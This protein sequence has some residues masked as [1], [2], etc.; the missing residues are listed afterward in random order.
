MPTCEGGRRGGG[1]LVCVRLYLVSCRGVCLVTCEER[2]ACG[3]V[4]F[5]PTLIIIH[6]RVKHKVKELEVG[7]C[8]IT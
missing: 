7:V 8:M 3:E 5:V 4:D 6:S 2:D 1:G